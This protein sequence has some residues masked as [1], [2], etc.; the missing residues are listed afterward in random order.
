[1][2]RLVA[3]V[4]VVL[5]A[6]RVERDRE[7]LG[8][9]PLAGGKATHVAG[10]VGDLEPVGVDHA[11]DLTERELPALRRLLEGVLLRRGVFPAPREPE[12]SVAAVGER[13][14]RVGVVT[15]D[16]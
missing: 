3:V 7:R 13:A 16:R 5:G 4:H 6:A 1:P 9:A 15:R 14:R 2:P 12:G 11:R 10:V 8:L